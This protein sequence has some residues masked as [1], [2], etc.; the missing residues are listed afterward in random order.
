MI[1]REQ[2]LK[3]LEEVGTPPDVVEHSKFVAKKSVEL[4]KKLSVPVDIQLVEIGALLHDIGR[5]QTHGIDHGI[6]G[7]IILKEYGLPKIAEFAETH[8][9]VGISKEDAAKLGL[10]KKNYIPKTLEQKIVCFVDFLADGTHMMSFAEALRKLK[11][12]VG[13]N[14]PAIQRAEELNQ[15]IAALTC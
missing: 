10:P 14:H 2:A 4:A 13:A 7:G 1:T 15:E 8:I 5:S 12:S 3:L 9:G 11:D 6:K